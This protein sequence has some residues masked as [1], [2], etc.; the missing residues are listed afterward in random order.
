M[1]ALGRGHGRGARAPS[2]QAT[3]SRSRTF[4]PRMLSGLR[5]LTRSVA[6][7][8]RFPQPRRASRACMSAAADPGS[9]KRKA[10]GCGLRRVA[11]YFCRAAARCSAAQLRA[12]LQADAENVRCAADGSHRHARRHLPRR[13]GTGLLAAPP[14]AGAGPRGGAPGTGR[15]TDAQPPLCPQAFKDAE[16]VRT[17]DP[18]RLTEL[19]VIIDVGAVYDPGAPFLGTCAQHTAQSADMC[20]APQRRTAMTTTSAAS[21]TSSAMVRACA[22]PRGSRLRAQNSRQRLMCS[23]TRSRRLFDQA[24]QRRP[25]VQALRPRGGGCGDAGAARRPARGDSIPQGTLLHLAA[26]VCRR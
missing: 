15:G 14:H 4:R 18:A 22:T 9:N 26:P 21:S 25:G 2:Q 12:L 3:C 5:L 17:R 16:V 6:A 13:R 24:F 23:W 19:D 10:R 8:A 7:A 20:A 1:H 11:Q